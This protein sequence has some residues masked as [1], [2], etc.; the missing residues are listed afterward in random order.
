M[1]SEILEAARA[2]LKWA[3]EAVE[4]AAATATAAE[5]RYRPQQRERLQRRQGG[6]AGPGVSGGTGPSGG[7][8]RDTSGLC[9]P[10]HI[11]HLS[12]ER[13]QQWRQR[14]RVQEE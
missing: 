2:A 9:S 12:R 7:G 13:P 11:Q 10:I 1:A 6:R 4:A 14:G 5:E 3:T 8:S